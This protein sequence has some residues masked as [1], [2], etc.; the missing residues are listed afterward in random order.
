MFTGSLFR[1]FCGGGWGR[2]RLQVSSLEGQDVSGEYNHGGAMPQLCQGNNA[3][4]SADN[5]FICIMSV[6][7]P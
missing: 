6:N 7:S 5:S 3:I 4:K 1:T 2:E